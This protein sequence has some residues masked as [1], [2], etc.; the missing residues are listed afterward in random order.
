MD[1]M[2]EELKSAGHVISSGWGMIS[3]FI[4]TALLARGLWHFRQVKMKRRKLFSMEVLIE[5]PIAVISIIVGLGIAEY[6]EIDGMAAQAIV[7]CVAW[8]GPRGV[9][10]ILCR[11]IER[12]SGL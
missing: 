10:D 4:F 1:A 9:E 7:G 8:L 2:L 11:F 5:I 6:L 3:G 12:K